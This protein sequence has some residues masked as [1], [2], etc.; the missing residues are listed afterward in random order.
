MPAT[1]PNPDE[2]SFEDA[3]ERLEEIVSAMEGERMPL[4][5]MVQSYAEGARLLK[6]CRQRIEVARQRVELITADLEGSGKA[7]LSAFD[8]TEAEAETPAPAKPVRTGNTRRSPAKPAA[9]NEE[10]GDDDIRLF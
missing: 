5:D 2:L 10:G 6:Q 4:E 1:P 8:A 9:D 3:M 7:S